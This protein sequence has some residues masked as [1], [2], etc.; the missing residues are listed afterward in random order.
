MEEA[1]GHK[2]QQASGQDREER[3]ERKCEAFV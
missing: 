2:E 1:A 3:Q